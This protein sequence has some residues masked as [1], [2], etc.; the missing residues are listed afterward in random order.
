DK[1]GMF[2]SA[3]AGDPN[4]VSVDIY[5]QDYRN[6]TDRLREETGNDC[7]YLLGHS[8]G[9]LMVSAAA[10]QM[11][12]GLCGVILVAAPGRMLGDVLREQLRA[13]PAN[14]PILNDAMLT[15]DRLEDGNNVDVS[16]MHPA[17]QGLFN[18]LVQDFL[19]SM[20]GTDPADLIANIDA[21]VLVVQGDRDIQV[22]VADAQRLSDAGGELVLLEGV[23]H[24]LKAAPEDRAGNLATYA[25]P[26]LPLADSVVPA[27][28][29]FVKG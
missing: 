3:A 22:A 1:R 18:P 5:A 9:G 21:P 6:W 25:D 2:A 23:N 16:D 7:V 12:T 24:I 4:A 15:I 29:A 19:I 10:T 26:D 11:E 14:A 8:E 20:F 17:L 13:N 28:V 27:I